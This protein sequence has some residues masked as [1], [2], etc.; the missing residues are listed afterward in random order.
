MVIFLIILLLIGINIFVFNRISFIFTPI[1]VLIK[2]VLLPIILSAI[3]YYLL[4]PIVNFFEKKGLRRVYTILALYIIIIGILTII[5]SSVIPFLRDQIISLVQNLPPLIS[6]IEH[7]IEGV[8][9]SQYLTRVEN[10]LNIDVKLIA[11]QFS[12]QATNLL[13]A[14]FVNILNVI[15]AVTEVA[16]AI[17]TLPFILFYLLKDGKKL[18]GYL[19]GFLPV[20]IRTQTYTVMKEM[21]SQISSY[22]RGQIIVSFCIGFLMFIGFTIIR[23][24][25]APVLALIAAFT[26]V[27]PY[28]GPAIAITPALIIAIVTSPFMLV[29]LII[30]W[31]IVQLIEGKFISP[32]IMGRNLRIHPITIIFIILTAGNLFGIVGILL[33]IPGYAILKVVATHTF[34]VLK[35]RSRLYETNLNEGKELS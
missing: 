3:M 33:A 10:T 21:N 30:V 24:D 1:A 27:V 23:L 11:T 14:T 15:G 4:V 16:L 12:E 20:N 8:I 9:G 29:K 5:I 6:D 19:L 2:T 35:R 34:E 17:I 22:I 32:Q 7:M 18:P 28:L 31:T 26:S 13:N 25:Y